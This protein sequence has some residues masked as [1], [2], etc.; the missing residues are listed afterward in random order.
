MFE[1]NAHRACCMHT[2]R[3]KPLQPILK[4]LNKTVF[5]GLFKARCSPERS[6]P[7]TL[8]RAPSSLIIEI[9]RAFSGSKELVSYHVLL[10]DAVA[11]VR[12]RRSLQ[13]D[14]RDQGVLWV[15]SQEGHQG[16]SA[17]CRIGARFQMQPCVTFSVTGW[18]GLFRVKYVNSHSDGAC[19]RSGPAQYSAFLK[20]V[21]PQAVPPERIGPD[22]ERPWLLAKLALAR[23]LQRMQV[24][25]RR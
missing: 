8:W 16:W 5:P 19:V 15:A 10:H 21:S 14:R 25:R 4:T 1:S 3:A 12:D 9:L 13:G 2:R 7:Y 24:R 11:P 6:G 20:E 17:C 23:T 18:L 22:E